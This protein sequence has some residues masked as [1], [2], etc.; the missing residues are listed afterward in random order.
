ML[1]N[2]ALPGRNL[3]ICNPEVSEYLDI[4]VVLLV[5][6]EDENVCF[7]TSYRGPEGFEMSH[8]GQKRGNCKRGRLTVPRHGTLQESMP[9]T[10]E[11][12]FQFLR[13]RDVFPMQG[14]VTSVRYPRNR[15]QKRRYRSSMQP[16]ALSD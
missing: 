5:L 9:S 12:Q 11:L 2:N 15:H 3:R 7:N 4:H 8:P 10:S 13:L 6:R 14:A 1:H 16:P